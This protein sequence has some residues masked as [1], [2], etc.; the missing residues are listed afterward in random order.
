MEN[1][2]EKLLSS[3]AQYE[4]I[5]PI[6]NQLLKTCRQSREKLTEIVK[7]SIENI[8]QSKTVKL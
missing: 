1:I 5:E 7:L 6:F 4:K 2:V 3:P 8:F